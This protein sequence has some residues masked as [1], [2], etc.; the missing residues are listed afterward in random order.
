MVTRWNLLRTARPAL[1]TSYNYVVTAQPAG[2]SSSALQAQCSFSAMR[3][4]DQL[5]VA[6]SLPK[7]SLA[8]ASV[9]IG[10]Q[11]YT[12]FPYNPAFGPLHFETAVNNNT[13]LLALRTSD[14]R[15]TVTLTS[16]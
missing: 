1:R 11:S 8:P 2:G 6:F 4:G 16:S 13:P 7:D 9:S 12:T 15:S 5:L 14:G 10:V 3:A